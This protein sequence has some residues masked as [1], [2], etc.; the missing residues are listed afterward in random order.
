[1]KE[2]AKDLLKI[3][4]VNYLLMNLLRGQVGSKV[5]SIVITV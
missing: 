2:I 1:M 3:Q 4:A 5:R